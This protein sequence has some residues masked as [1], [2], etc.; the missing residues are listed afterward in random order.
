MERPVADR[1]MRASTPETIEADLE[2]L[3]R[4]LADRTSVTRAMM[5]NLVVFRNCPRADEVDLDAC[6]G[7]VPIAEVVR[8]HPSRLI[9]LVH[10]DDPRRLQAPLAASIGIR[11]FGSGETR[12]AIEQIT[13][14]SV[15]A[16]ASLPS[17]VRRLILGDLPTSVW[18][19]E[20]LSQSPPPTALVTMGRQFVYDSRQWRDARAGLSTMAA[21]LDRQH[22][23]DVADVNW[24]RL[25]P[26]RQA[27]QLG[28]RSLI[29]GT[30]GTPTRV[31]VR[32]HRLDAAKAWLLAGWLASDPRPGPQGKLVTT[33]DEGDIASPHLSV[34][35]ESGQ[36]LALSAEMDDT[37]VVVRNTSTDV[38]VAVRVPSE[39]V[40]EA[41]AA[42]LHALGRAVALTAAIGAANARLTAAA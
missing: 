20:D 13:V 40:A 35:I 19:T 29:P 41:I 42:E 30:A 14:R 32:H 15:C 2:A 23:P 1:V 37:Q 33:V 38:T 25:G 39:S 4:E 26:M 7:E 8:R 3:W 21:L 11:V 34:A 31:Q 27:L 12:H 5:S 18:W 16:E 9:V 24:R 6:V 10:Q 28:L 17:I 36:G 22:A